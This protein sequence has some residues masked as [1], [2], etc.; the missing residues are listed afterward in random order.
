MFILSSSVV[1]YQGAG[2]K[3][4]FSSVENI[5]TDVSLT[6]EPE[7]EYDNVPSK[8]THIPPKRKKG[9]NTKESICVQQTP[10]Q[11]ESH[12]HLSLG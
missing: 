6:D 11:K 2:E 8:L 7:M 3:K 9:I 5:Q 1:I 12:Q 4:T 10:K